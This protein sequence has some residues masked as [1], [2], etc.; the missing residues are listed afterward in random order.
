MDNRREM[1]EPPFQP[2]SFEHIIRLLYGSKRGR[3]AQGNYGQDEGE[4]LESIL[5]AMLLVDDAVAVHQEPSVVA[6]RLQ[7]GVT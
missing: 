2:P 3:Y 1:I 4:P 6:A 5:E 7:R